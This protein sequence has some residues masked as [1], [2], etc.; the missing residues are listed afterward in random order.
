MIMTGHISLYMIKKEGCYEEITNGVC[1]SREETAKLGNS[2]K[3]AY[4]NRLKNYAL[5][6]ELNQKSILGKR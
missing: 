2:G 3:F 6:K 5:K 4:K 1:G